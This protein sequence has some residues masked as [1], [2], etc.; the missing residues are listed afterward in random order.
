MKTISLNNRKRLSRTISRP[1]VLRKVP[2]GIQGLDE[3]TGGGLPKGRSTLLC[4]GAGS[5]KTLLAMEFLV[6]G[7]KEFKEPGVFVAFEEQTEELAQNF[8]SL[9]H[10]L[11]T[12]VA[13]K[14]LAIDFVHIERGEIQETGEYNLEGL[15]IRLEH[16][17]DSIGA[18]RVVLD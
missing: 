11:K 9:G 4:G 7:V 12:L 5:G 6:R 3:L 10:D 15:F 8:A 14:K 17:I 13:Q 18:S 1:P 16:A 2:T